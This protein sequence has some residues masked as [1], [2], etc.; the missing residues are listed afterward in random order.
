MAVRYAP[1]PRR[2]AAY[3][4]DVAVLVPLALVAAFVSSG[5]VQFWCIVANIALLVLNRWV[6]PAWNGRTIG[7]AAMRIQL[8]GVKTHKPVH[9]GTAFARDI[10]HAL[11][12][13]TLFI[14]WI[15]PL[16]QDQH[17]TIADSLLDST[18]IVAD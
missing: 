5:K 18:V 12:T 6:L 16:W 9:I 1:W 17:Q 13:L 2:A 14:G 10:A 8:V 3:L 15:R 11:D 7:R 4:I